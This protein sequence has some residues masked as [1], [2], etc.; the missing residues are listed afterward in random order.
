MFDAALVA[1]LKSP[2]SRIAKPLVQR[3]VTANQLTWIGFG[4]GVLGALAVSLDALEWALACLLLNRLLDGLDGAVARASTPT[5]A[6]AFLDI[7]LDF[8]IYSLYPLAFALRDPSDA[9]AAAFLIFSFV[10][11]G[12]TFL[13][14]SIFAK[15]RGLENSRLKEKSIYYLEG[16][17]EGFETLLVLCAMCLFPGWF[18]IIAMGFGGLC[19]VTAS[20]R[21]HRGFTLLRG[22]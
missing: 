4:I 11:T 14:F 2:L 8:L 15:A 20:M 17:T 22:N 5:D 18:Q 19:L 6:G 7:V 1:R 10:A 13:A 3:G 16:L 9:L 12:T 21:I